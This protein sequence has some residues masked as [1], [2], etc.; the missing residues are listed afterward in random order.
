MLIAFH[1]ALDSRRARSTPK[2]IAQTSPLTEARH[3]FKSAPLTIGFVLFKPRPL[4]SPA[5]RLGADGY[6]GTT[7]IPRNRAADGAPAPNR[8]PGRMVR[9][10]RILRAV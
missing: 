9:A 4:A 7:A 1:T 2:P 8:Q 10:G 5:N 6:F 3:R